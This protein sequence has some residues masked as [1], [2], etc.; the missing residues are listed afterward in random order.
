MVGVALLF[1]FPFYILLNLSLRPQYCSP[2]PCHSGRFHA[3]QL[4]RRVE[5]GRHRPRDLQQRRRHRPERLDRRDC[6]RSRP[7]RWRGRRLAGRSGSSRCS[8]SGC[9]CRSSSRCCPSTRRSAT[10]TCSAR[11]GASSCSTAG[12]RSVL[13][14]PVHR[15]PARD[16]ARLREGGADRRRQPAPGVP[17]RRLPA[18]ATGHGHRRDLNAIFVWN[19]F[20]TPL[21]YLSGSDRDGRDLTF[22]GQYVELAARLRRPPHGV[23]PILLVYFAMQR[24]IIRGFAGGLKG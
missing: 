24:H 8:C 4:P 12:C 11:C 7:T 23:A 14:L 16:A 18:A 3:R 20:L 10:C 19:D 15:V 9:C 22:V 17:R 2:T 6:R 5:R 1:A 13:R 21:L